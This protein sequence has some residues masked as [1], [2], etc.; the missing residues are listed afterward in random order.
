MDA[1]GSAAGAAASLF[2]GAG[3]GE[4]VNWGRNIDKSTLA[5]GFTVAGGL[6]AATGLVAGFAAFGGSDHAMFPFR[7]VLGFE[8]MSV[9]PPP[10]N[11][12][13]T[14]AAGFEGSDVF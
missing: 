10:P 4:A 2:A 8:S 14:E 9:R 13:V 11:S 6:G 7:S 3:A 12:G 5:A 1:L